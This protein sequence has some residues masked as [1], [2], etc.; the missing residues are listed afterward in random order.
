MAVDAGIIAGVETPHPASAPGA[1]APRMRVTR[2]IVALRIVRVRVGGPLRHG[3]DF[4]RPVKNS[5]RREELLGSQLQ[6][7]GA[8]AHHDDLEASVVIEVHVHRRSDLIA[9]VV[10]HVRD[11][12]GK[13]ANVV[14]V[15]DRDAGEGFHPLARQRSHELAARE[16]AK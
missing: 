4:D 10:L 3:H 14:V 8:T 5:A 11:A 7:V 9:Q 15:Y 2:V 6:F 12:F 16:I 13:L 1:R